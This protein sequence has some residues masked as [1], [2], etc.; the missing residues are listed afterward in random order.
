MAQFSNINVIQLFS[1][2]DIELAYHVRRV[3]YV[4]EYGYAEN[5][6]TDEDDDTAEHFAA[7]ADLTTTDKVMKR[8]PVGTIRLFRLPNNVARLGR[9]AVI[10]DARG[11]KIGRLLVESFI[12][13]AKAKGYDS[14]VLHA[15][16]EKRFFYEKLGFNVEE[17]DDMEFEEDG[18]PH[19][20]LW[21]RQL[22]AT[23]A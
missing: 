7:V 10:A 9:V 5:V 16:S 21:M 13:H 6:V 14:I 15:V 1:P 18:T 17:G 12:E 19:L 20:R 2:E 4:H 23:A 11:L 3:V 8:V 22:Q